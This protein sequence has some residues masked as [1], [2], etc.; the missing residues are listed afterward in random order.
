[1]GLA[2]QRVQREK[3][4]AA[5][6]DAETL[7]WRAAQDARGQILREGC[8]YAATGE[9]RWQIVRSTVGRTDQRD[10]LVNGQLFKTCGPRRLPA[11]LR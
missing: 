9:Q 2:S 1:M 11:W 8:T 10:V 4:A 7:R 5:S 6:I 3:R